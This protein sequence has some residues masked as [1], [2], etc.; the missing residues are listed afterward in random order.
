MLFRGIVPQGTQY[1]HMSSSK[2]FVPGRFT[3][4]VLLLT[5]LLFGCISGRLS[6]LRETSHALTIA[7]TGDTNGY[8]TMPTE[9][10]LGSVA[11][12]I[13]GKDIFTFNAEGVFSEK[14]NPKD[15]HKFRNQSLFLGSPA[16]IDSLPRGKITV[17]SLANNHILD[18]GQNGLIETILELRKRGIETVGAGENAEEACR[19]LMLNIKGLN[20]A[21][22]AYLEIDP[23]VLDYI[24]MNP[25]WFLA[26]NNKA[27]VASWKLCNGQKKI[28]EIRKEADIILAL[29]HMHQSTF[30]WTDIPDAEGVLFVKK[31]LDSG[32][33]IVLGSGAHFPQ[34]VISN[35][36]GIA[37]FSLGNFLMHP[38]NGMPEKGYR[39]FLADF[40]ISNDSMGLTVVPLR[41]DIRGIPKVVSEGDAN[42]IINRIVALSY[43]LGTTMEMREDRGYVEIKRIPPGNLPEPN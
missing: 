39:S 21:V 6:N 3:S 31:M 38:D 37:V 35:N 33:D 32:A 29:V 8:N 10:Q 1:N 30:S 14:L 40:T 7:A 28:A 42:I 23:K 4:A 26:G 20:V 12:F 15:C 25:A 18:C 19:P 27:G 34:G 13:S 9:D 5:S 36:K 24:G 22:L 2:T 43:Q 17:A 41:L 16:V 11:A